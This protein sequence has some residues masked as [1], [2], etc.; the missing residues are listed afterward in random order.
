MSP[1]QDLSRFSGKV[2]VK[3]KSSRELEETGYATF[4]TLYLCVFLSVELATSF[5]W[6]L[7]RCFYVSLNFR[8]H[9]IS[10]ISRTLEN[11]LP[12]LDRTLRNY[13]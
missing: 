2:T 3:R 5:Q 13:L 6:N 8:L 7:S 12:E 11:A 1:A 4:K 10:G 9:P